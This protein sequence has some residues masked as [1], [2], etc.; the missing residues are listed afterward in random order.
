MLVGVVPNMLAL[1]GVVGL[2]LGTNEDGDWKLFQDIPLSVLTIIW[3]A[4]CV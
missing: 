4:V 3:P 1:G 2:P